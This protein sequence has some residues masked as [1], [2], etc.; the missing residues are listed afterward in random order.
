MSWYIFVHDLWSQAPTRRGTDRCQVVVQNHRYTLLL[1]CSLWR[2]RIFS[3]THDSSLSSSNQWHNNKSAARK[4]FV[5]LPCCCR[6]YVYVVLFFFF[7]F[8]FLAKHN[9]VKCQTLLVM[10]PVLS[11]AWFVTRALHIGHVSCWFNHC[12]RHLEKEDNPRL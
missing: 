9:C 10:S 12:C 8:F 4:R 2:L 7:F 5:W 6:V 1:L 3:V 11:P